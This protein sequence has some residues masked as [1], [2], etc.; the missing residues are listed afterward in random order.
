MTGK[1]LVAYASKGGATE[2]AAI[3]I[4]KVLKEKNKLSVDIVNLRKEKVDNLSEYSNIVA[5]AGVRIGKI[6]KEFWKLLEKDFSGKKLALFIVCG[7]AIDP[8]DH[9]RVLGKH[10]KTILSKHPNLK[11][12]EFDVFGGRIKMLWKVVSDGR[13]P[14]KVRAW[15]EKVEKKLKE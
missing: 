6:Y 3:E 9:D 1:T 11:L 13:D 5:G 14:K 4:T 10:M 8:N 7:E 15:A 12:I 2:E